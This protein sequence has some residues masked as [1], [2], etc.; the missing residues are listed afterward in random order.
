MCAQAIARRLQFGVLQEEL[1]H[2]SDAVSWDED[3]GAAMPTAAR[4]FR[5]E[6]KAAPDPLT[7]EKAVELFKACKIGKEKIGGETASDLLARTA[8]PT[9]AVT[10]AAIERRELGAAEARPQAAAD[11]PRPRAD[12]LP[13]RAGTRCRASGRA[14]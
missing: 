13:V 8:T 2:V 3:D 12:D 9:L 1:R 10:T 6:F 5:D 11:G 7:A 4:Y 14:R